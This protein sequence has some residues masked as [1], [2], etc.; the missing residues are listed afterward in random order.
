MILIGIHGDI[1]ECSQFLKKHPG[2]GIRNIFLNHFK[3]KECTSSFERYHYSNNPDEMLIRAK[4]SGYDNETGIYYV[5]PYFFSKKRIPKYFHFFPNDILGLDFIK[6]KKEMSF[7]LTPS[8]I[9]KSNCL[10]I[11]YKNSKSEVF[12]LIVKKTTDNIWY[13]KWKNIHGI[14]ESIED[15]SIE[16]II[17]KT[18]K[19]N[20]FEGILN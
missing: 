19:E 9:N 11:T 2:E 13:T 3:F 15:K 4:N 7:I 17:K 1:Y 20:N 14:E 6:N 18:M 10:N 16:N 5:C 12:Q 8:K